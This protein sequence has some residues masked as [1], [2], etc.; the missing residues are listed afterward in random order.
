MLDNY[1]IEGKKTFLFPFNPKADLEF[2]VK[3][4]KQHA[5]KTQFFDK[6]DTDDIMAVKIM[7]MI[8]SGAFIVWTAI[9][10]QGKGARKMGF[11]YL[12]SV[13]P[14]SVNVHGLLDV[15]FLKDIVRQLEERYTYTEDC[16]KSFIKYCFE[17]LKLER[18]ETFV[19][20]D[21]RLAFH[22]DK[23]VGFKVEGRFRNYLDDGNGKFSSVVAMSI[24]KDE[25]L[26]LK[27][28]KEV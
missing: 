19:R 9:T 16:Y 3:V 27:E 20:E 1:I 22:I 7:Q 14:H 15:Q 25:Y 17:T 6:D 2:L 23:K 24:L 13:K 18:I 8:Q 5:E 21:N 11:I 28:N 4:I 26:A 10:K 12:T